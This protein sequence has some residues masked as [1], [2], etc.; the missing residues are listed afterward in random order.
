MWYDATYVVPA[1]TAT[2]DEKVTCCQ[3]EA[4]SPENDADANNAPVEDHSDPMWTP[5]FAADL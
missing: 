5:V 4:D 2:G 1:V 3:P